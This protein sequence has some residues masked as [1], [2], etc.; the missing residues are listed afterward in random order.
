M[1]IHT[2]PVAA[3]ATRNRK[4][5]KPTDELSGYINIHCQWASSCSPPSILP[6]CNLHHLDNSFTPTAQKWTSALIVVHTSTD[7]MLVV[8]NFWSTLS[9]W[10]QSNRQRRLT[11]R[12]VVDVKT[13]GFQQHNL[14][15]S[16]NY[17]CKHQHLIWHRL[18]RSVCN[19][20]QNPIYYVRTAVISIRS[21]WSTCI[22]YRIVQA[23]SV[24]GFFRGLR[25]H[26]I[27]VTWDND[28]RPSHCSAC[29]HLCVSTH[30][31]ADVAA[32]NVKCFSISIDGS[33]LYTPA[34]S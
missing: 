10:K 21:K 6:D 15:P 4:A 29:A 31:S 5:F 2:E 18:A 26:D 23:Y 11:P 16:T 27:D 3:G 22:I 14:A 8:C 28:K 13:P 19:S 20:I 7:T 9:H 17:I 34:V 30:C 25:L 24:D 12:N 1:S 33:P 32:R